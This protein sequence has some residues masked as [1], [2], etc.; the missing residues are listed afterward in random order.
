M[1]TAIRLGKP[2]PSHYPRTEELEAAA[3]RKAENVAG[4]VRTENRVM[5][6]PD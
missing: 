1:P 6:S 3:T 4:A 5:P 2:E